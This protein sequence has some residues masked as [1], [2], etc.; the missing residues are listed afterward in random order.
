MPPQGESAGIA[1]EDAVIV[2]RVMATNDPDGLTGQMKRYERLR[3]P[4]VDTAYRESTFGWNTLKDSGWL[5]F[6]FRCLLT[7]MFL[8]WTAGGRVQRYSEDL[9]TAALDQ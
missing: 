3:R 5:S 6:Q 7:W 1:L 2:G 8:W 9:A 4:R